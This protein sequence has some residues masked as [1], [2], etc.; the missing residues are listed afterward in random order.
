MAEHRFDTPYYASVVWI[1]GY[2]WTDANEFCKRKFGYGWFDG[3]RTWPCTDRAS[4]DWL[5]IAF[6][7]RAAAQKAADALREAG[8]P[9][10]HQP[11]REDDEVEHA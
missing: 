7:T 11:V 5:G 4:E 3:N 6:T 2:R 8:F 9:L 10:E 1:P